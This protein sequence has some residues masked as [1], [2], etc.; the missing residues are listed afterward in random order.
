MLHVGRYRKLTASALCAHQGHR[1]SMDEKDETGIKGGLAGL[2]DFS[3]WQIDSTKMEVRTARRLVAGTCSNSHCGP[4]DPSC[5]HG[6]CGWGQQVG[7]RIAGGSFADLHMGV[8]CG[9]TV[10]VKVLRTDPTAVG[11]SAAST[12]LQEEFVKE[13]S[14]LRK[15]CDGS[16]H[17][18][19]EHEWVPWVS[20]LRRVC[21][22]SFAQSAT[23]HAMP[24]PSAS[25]NE[26][27]GALLRLLHLGVLS[28][29]SIRG[30]RAENTPPPT[31]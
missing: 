11:D 2:G 17:G 21:Q 28:C 18:G 15:V 24:G 3:D 7:P 23:E 1:K 13:V 5:P 27:W 29:S 25:W 14:I 19:A 4:A 22:H 9:Q 26:E 30:S 8:Y 6:D 10:A 31:W 20:C 16:G 12:A